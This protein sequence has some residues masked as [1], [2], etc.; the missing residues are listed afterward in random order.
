MTPAAANLVIKPAINTA[1]VA[2]PNTPV[3]WPNVPFTPPAGP[4]L[5]VDV[6]WGNGRAATKGT[7]GGVNFVSAILQLAIF[8]PKD[9]GDG[10]LY[11]LAEAARAL[12]NRRRL[13]SP[14]ADILFGAASGPV[15]RNEESWRS[16]VVST[17]FT[18]HEVVS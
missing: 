9:A 15:I 8:A 3:A 10:S 16:L 4:W 18:V 17:P 13:A 2:G 14:N 6:I 7:A 12:F 5:K 11:T 1:W